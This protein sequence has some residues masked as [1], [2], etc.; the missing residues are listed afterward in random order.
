MAK[1]YD[2]KEARKEIFKPL[3]ERVI[4]Y[5]SKF[6]KASEVAQKLKHDYRTNAKDPLS[7]LDEV[8]GEQPVEEKA[9]VKSKRPAYRTI[10]DVVAVAGVG[11]LELIHKTRWYYPLLGALPGK[12]QEKIADKRK[13]KAVYYII[14]SAILE[15]AAL[16]VTGCLLFGPVALLPVL[17]Y[18]GIINGGR[19]LATA[20]EI[21]LNWGSLFVTLP[22]YLALG[23]ILGI[24][25]AGK[26]IKNSYTS[27]WEKGKALNFKLEPQTLRIKQ[28]EPAQIVDAELIEAEQEVEDFLAEEDIRS[29]NYS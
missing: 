1:E 18:S 9:I 12:Y 23:A 21:D 22:Y 5:A 14:S 28:A 11:T 2:P 13:E 10:A 4:D 16:G 6:N 27:A 24:T 20:T 19:S 8:C 7:V 15:S 26:A 25:A 17:L 3:E 29:Q